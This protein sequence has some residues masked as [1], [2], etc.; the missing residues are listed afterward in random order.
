MGGDNIP[1][2]VSL[3]AGSNPL[4]DPT[5]M[6]H[7]V[8]VVAVGMAA[9]ASST[10]PRSRGVVIIVLWERCMRGMGCMTYRGEEDVEV[11]GLWLK[12]KESVMNQM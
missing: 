4:L 8:R 5:F 9:R 6:D 10:S 7:I 11:V 2:S 1:P 12:K 3:V